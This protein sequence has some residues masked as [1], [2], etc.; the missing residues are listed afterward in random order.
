MIEGEPGGKLASYAAFRKIFS[1]FAL[2]ND[3]GGNPMANQKAW[4][5]D[6]KGFLE[7]NPQSDEA[8]DA[9][10]QLASAHEYNAEEDDARQYYQKLVEGYAD[11]DQGKKA[12]GALRR[13]DLVGKTFALQ[14]HGLNQQVV[15][16]SQFR[17]KTVLVN[18]WASWADPVRRDLPELVKLYKKYHDQGFEIVGVCLDE[19]PEDLEQFLKTNP[20]PWTQ[21]YEPGGL[22]KNPLAASYGI[23]ALP[24]MIL[25]DSQGKVVNRNIRTAAE[26]EKQLE[27]VVTGKDGGVALGGR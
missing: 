24:T 6:L 22:E 3:E 15:D 5:A 27:K 4:M 7:K 21:I 25:V 9:L 16:V 2:K 8:P 13:L 20:I 18:F 17:G 14:G 12:A 11:T 23:I 19:R 1:E 26:L 10:L